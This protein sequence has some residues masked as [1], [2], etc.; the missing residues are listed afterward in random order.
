MFFIIILISLVN[1]MSEFSFPV[2]FEVSLV[3]MVVTLIVGS[4]RL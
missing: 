4:A 1:A 2:S 3:Y